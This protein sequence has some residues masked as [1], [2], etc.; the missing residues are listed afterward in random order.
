MRER[1]QENQQRISKSHAH[2]AQGSWINLIQR[3][4]Q[5]SIRRSILLTPP[6]NNKTPDCWK[7][8]YKSIKGHLDNCRAKNTICNFC[9]KIGHYA[10]V[11]R[12]EIPPRR[13]E[14]QTEGI[15]RSSQNHNYPRAQQQ[16]TSQQQVNARRVKKY[17]TI[18]PRWRNNSRRRK[19][20]INHRPRK[21]VLHPRNDGGLELSKFHTNHSTLPQSIKQIWIKTKKE[22]IG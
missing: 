16:S 7:C 6:N 13:P 2:I 3:T 15:Q 4:R 1:W 10:K 20:N 22:N 5:Q 18:K 17:T 19:R 14:T 12:S 8:G 21:Y 11:W 9:N